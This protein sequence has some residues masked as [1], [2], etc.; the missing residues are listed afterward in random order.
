MM[1][2]A[3]FIS[4]FTSPL[5]APVLLGLVMADLSSCSPFRTVSWSPCLFAARSWCSAISTT[6]S[7]DVILWKTTTFSSLPRMYDMA[8][9]S[10]AGTLL[11]MYV[12][13]YVW[14]CVCVC[15]CVRVY[16]WRRRTRD[17]FAY[18]RSYGTLYWGAQTPSTFLKRS[19]MDSWGQNKAI[20]QH[21]VNVPQGDKRDCVCF[22]SLYLMTM[23]HMRHLVNI[24]REL[25]AIVIRCFNARFPI[26]A[27]AEHTFTKFISHLDQTSVI[28]LKD[29]SICWAHAFNDYY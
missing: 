19:S 6:N 28:W 23:T 9:N 13:M 7:I 26:C 5:G 27:C 8:D 16:V 20:A 21:L 14:V 2:S 3:F 15:M 12:C 22:C 4:R 25:G 17:F 24:Q 1:C 11:C 18:M 29:L 10:F